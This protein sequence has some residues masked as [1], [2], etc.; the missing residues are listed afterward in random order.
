MRM[1]AACAAAVLMPIAAA[2][3]SD[4]AAQPGPAAAQ[5]FAVPAQPG[6]APSQSGAA[7]SQ[8][9][10]IVERVH[11]GFLAAPDFKVTDVD[12]R[13]SEL[14]G[15]YAGW[16]ADETFFVGGAGYWLANGSSDREMAY[17]GLMLQW[18]A[19]SSNRLGV[20]V[21]GLIGGGQA[22]LA[23]TVTTYVPV[24]VPVLD[25]RNLLP[26][27]IDP[28]MVVHPPVPT[29]LNVRFREDFVVAEPEVDL[30]FRISRQVR[31]TAGAGYRFVGSD[32]RGVDDGRLRGA[33]G[34]VAL[35]IGGGS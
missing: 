4:A 5:L 2:A 16:L 17:G 11:S 3:Q 15:G 24:P 22:T 30:L 25:P 35:Q 29:T 33:T 20:G 14:V 13:T 10:M 8:G 19:E 9:P 34:S 28:G 6:A 31:V 21:K 32:R 7:P 23:S 1:V 12:K 27:R 26:G 18:L